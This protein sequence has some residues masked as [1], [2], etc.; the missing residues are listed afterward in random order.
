M[1][2]ITGPDGLIK[3]IPGVYTDV[4]VISSLPGPLPAFQIPIMLGRA[5]EGKPYNFDS[6]RQDSEAEAG[7]FELCGTDGAIARAFGPGCDL[8]RGGKFAKRHD[9][10]FAYVASLSALTRASVV[11]TSAGPVNQFTLYPRRFGTPAGHMKVT[12]SATTM[13][14]IPVK[15]Y[16]FLT[17]DA[18]IGD[19]R[20][21]LNRTDWIEV[22]QTITIGDN[23]STNEDAEVVAKGSLIAN[24]QTLYFVDIDVGLAA[25]ATT[26]QYGIVLEY[27]ETATEELAFSGGGDPVI[28][29]INENSKLFLAV[30]HADFTGANPIALAVATALKDTTTWA[31]PTD[32]TSPE[33]TVTDV[34]AFVTLMN[35]GGWAAFATRYVLLPQAYYLVMSDEDS[36]LAMRDYA[37]AERLRG[38]PISVT[39]GCAWGDVD[40]AA[41]DST[42]PMV[43]A[44]ALNCDS[45][46]L[47]A[48]GFDQE[49]A[50]ISLAGAA[51]GRR[52][53]GGPK[54]NLTQD[55][56]LYSTLEVQWDEIDSLELTS[57]HRKGVMT[58]RMSEATP[59]RHVIS[60]GLTT[61][62]NNSGLIWLEVTK[63][64]WSCMQRDLADFV[65]RVLKE[66][67][68][69]SQLGADGVTP[70]SI[71][72][73][74][75]RRAQKSLE[76]REYIKPGSH[77]ITL[78]TLNEG[79]SGYDVVQDFKLPDTVDYITVLSNI[80]I[81]G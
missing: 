49:P 43:R 25:A 75:V 68:T 26:A 5:W 67:L 59:Y 40:L 44:A 46:C 13:T 64:T 1:P 31:A 12:L 53:R 35:A 19:T 45:V 70:A 16:S 32:G 7:P 73:V 47:A 38:F 30:K 57:L 66:D 24:G 62:Q 63:E 27:D 37:I 42:N 76:P 21:W 36:H 65:C 10:P 28:D 69:Q 23:N 81:D 55:T 50:Y 15:N 54:H 48:G 29:G 58:Y 51:F 34:D 72:T 18:A 41:V 22:G 6:L 9:L 8:H 52:V 11:I 4:R 78:I 17:T 39:T 80:L 2:Q 74:L 3:V 77:R 61:L 56:L 60:Q 79:A 71:S 33:P 20:L 14:A